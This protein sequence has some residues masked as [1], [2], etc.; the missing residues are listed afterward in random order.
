[1]THSI[2]AANIAQMSKSRR[3]GSSARSSGSS[4]ARCFSLNAKCGCTTL[5]NA[6]G[7][8]GVGL[9]VLLFER[10]QAWCGMRV[11]YAGVEWLG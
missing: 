1:M 6:R 4:V 9:V 3:A 5:G 11:W 7:G 8:G 2:R 10:M